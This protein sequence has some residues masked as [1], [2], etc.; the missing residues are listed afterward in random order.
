MNNAHSHAIYMQAVFVFSVWAAASYAAGFCLLGEGR[1]FL[2]YI[3]FFS[4]VTTDLSFRD[5]RIEPGFVLLAWVF[6]NILNASYDQY[7][8]FIIAIALGLKIQL[9]YRHCASPLLAFV[10]YMVIFYPLLEYTQIRTVM[11]AESI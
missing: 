7:A 2:N 10:A 1:D 5:F 6:K 3:Y 8:T 4:S 11:V 9:F